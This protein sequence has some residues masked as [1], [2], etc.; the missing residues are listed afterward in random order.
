MLTITETLDAIRAIDTD[1]EVLRNA[2]RRMLVP[3]HLPPTTSLGQQAS[4]EICASYFYRLPTVEFIEALSAT[5]VAVTLTSANEGKH[6]TA[7]ATVLEQLREM[8]G[9]SLRRVLGD[10]D[11]NGPHGLARQFDEMLKAETRL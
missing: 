11:P 7:V 4:R 8:F 6:L 1:P 9:E 3:E 5:L 2:C 10:K